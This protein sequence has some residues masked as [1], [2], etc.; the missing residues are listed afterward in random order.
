VLFRLV[1]SAEREDS[2]LE[3]LHDLEKEGL[4]KINDELK[5]TNLGVVE[6]NKTFARLL[7]EEPEA[8]LSLLRNLYLLRRGSA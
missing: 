1:T 4:L 3:A 2:L 5:I 6:F 8:A 7:D